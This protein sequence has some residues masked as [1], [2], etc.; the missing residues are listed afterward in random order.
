[1]RG[2]VPPTITFDGSL[3]IDGGDMTFEFSDTP[4]HTRRSCFDL[5]SRSTSVAFLAML[6]KRRYHLC[7]PPRCWCCARRLSGLR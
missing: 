6:P 1:M 7:S 3:T 5:R 4:G 2:M